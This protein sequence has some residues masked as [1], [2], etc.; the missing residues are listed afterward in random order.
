MRRNTFT[1]AFSILLLLTVTVRADRFSDLWYDGNAELST[2]RLREMR[3]GEP[4]DGV[5]IMVFVT[6]PMR[7]RT[8]IKPDTAL[9]DSL[10]IPVFKLNDLRKFA[11]GIYDYSVM[12]SVFSAVEAAH[13][14]PLWSDMKVAF[15]SQEWCG[16]VFERTVR[17]RESYDGVL[18]S[19]FESEGEQR[20]S[21]PAD[22][23]V[24]TEDGLWVRIREL[25][26]PRMTQ[27]QE[28][29]LRV[30]PS[31]WSRRKTH[32]TPRLMDVVLRRHGTE[33]LSTA[34]GAVD[35]AK[36]T[37]TIEGQTTSV[38]VETAYPHRILAWKEP[39]GS[40]GAIMASQREP[41]W[42]QNG[43]GDESLR[44]MLELAPD[45]KAFRWP[46]EPK[47]KPYLS[48]VP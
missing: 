45:R 1:L 33:E 31:A 13:G 29:H 4:R 40:S 34:L 12:T 44:R 8:H 9:P 48:T 41:Y 28:R 22:S 32:E 21:L 46:W 43:N 2:Y 23:A 11:T 15:T 14:H 24:Q 5:R 27:G 7:L 26:G 10:E 38:W 36:F 30:I 17:N 25:R 47:Q 18:Y 35:A 42:K 20:F 19:Y 16:T 3:Y 39:D 37:W 6:E